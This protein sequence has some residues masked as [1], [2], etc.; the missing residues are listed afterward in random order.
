MNKKHQVI[1]TIL[2]QM[3][4]DGVSPLIFDNN[5]V[6]EVSGDSFRNQFDATKF[7]TS[8]RLPLFLREEDYFILHLGDGRHQF[9]RGIAQGYH[10]FEAIADS[11]AIVHWPY[12]RSLLNDVHLNASSL[13]HFLDN[14][15]ILSHFLAVVDTDLSIYWSHRTSCSF[16][17]GVGHQQ[18]SAK[19][20]RIQIDMATECGGIVGVIE[21]RNRFQPDFPMYQLYN[22]FRYY[23]DQTNEL[24]IKDVRA[25]YALRSGKGSNSRLRLY[26]YAFS[27]PYDSS[28]LVLQ[29][30]VEYRLF[31][32][33]SA[34]VCL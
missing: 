30:S 28:S 4:N 20:L 22:P 34:T 31:E 8:D 19:S 13:V 23:F 12:R 1:E 26:S 14:Q 18:I 6:K 29:K 9:V 24:G 10:S 11:D 27:D 32:E 5:R 15:G 33:R 16:D 25:I 7:D 21:A 3:L 2:R 17:F